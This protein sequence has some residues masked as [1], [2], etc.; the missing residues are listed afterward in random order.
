MIIENE[1]CYGIEYVG[2]LTRDAEC[3]PCGP[4]GQ[5]AGTWDV[6][7]FLGYGRRLPAHKWMLLGA[8]VA[9]PRQWRPKEKPFSKALAY[10]FYSAPRQLLAQIAPIGCHL[11]KAGSCVYLYSKAPSGLLYLFVNDWW[12]TAANNSGGPRLRIQR[13]SAADTQWPLYSLG[14]NGKHWAWSC[15]TSDYV[16]PRSTVSK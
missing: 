15:E 1:A 5:E 3:P 9:H 11:T 4:D 10:L 2:G 14:P 16:A 13:V 7:R 8:T 12:Q 6:R